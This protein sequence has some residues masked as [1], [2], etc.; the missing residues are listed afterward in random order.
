MQ[1]PIVG[2]ELSASCYVQ[3]HTPN[4]YVYPIGF[5][6]LERAAYCNCAVMSCTYT[7]KYQSGFTRTTHSRSR[8]HY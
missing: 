8:V 3:L 5:D 6:I 4:D 1:Y 7:V 2:S